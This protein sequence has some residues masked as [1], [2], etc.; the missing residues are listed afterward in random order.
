MKFHN[1]LAF[2]LAFMAS[3]FVAGCGGGGAAA[4]PDKLGEIRIQPEEGFFYAGVVGIITVSGG[5]APYSLTSS[6]P[7]VLPVPAILHGH[8]FQ[9]IPNN[10]GVVDSDI[11]EGEVPSRSV[12]IAVRDSQSFTVEAVIH[13]AQN[14]LTGYSFTFGPTTCAE[15]TVACAGGETAL[16][17]SPTA[18]ALRRGNVPM[19]LEITRGPCRWTDPIGTNN[20]VTIYNTRTDHAGI[21]T[22]ILKCPGGITAQIGAFRIV[23]VDSG[24]SVEHVFLI[25]SEP[26]SE[27]DL[28]AIPDSFTFTGP[29]TTTCG[30]G[31]AD[32]LVFGGQPPFTAISSAPNAVSVTPESTS[33]PGRFTINAFNPAFCVSDASIIVQDSAGGRVIVSVTTEP[34]SADPPAPPA[35]TVSP[36]TMTLACNTCGTATVVGGSGSYTTSSGHPGITVTPVVGGNFNICRV[37][38]PP[39]GPDGPFAPTGNVSV[40]DGS[41]IRS[42]TVTVPTTCP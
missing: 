17:F 28:V 10:P 32:F 33:N 7:A 13:V 22:A 16:R 35:M 14:F 5:R 18:N 12:T 29:N 8:S 25:S 27:G 34:G 20:L 31:V 37:T 3:L 19:R 15:G 21:I 40:S 42:V 9:V 6:E 23:D 30:T 2:L 41:Q 1:F 36:T 4:D 39:P 26:A 11:T 38:S 24:V